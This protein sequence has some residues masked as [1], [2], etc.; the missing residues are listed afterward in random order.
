[1]SGQRDRP[2][3]S[4]A[5]ARAGVEAFKRHRGSIGDL[6]EHNEGS[7]KPM[8][9]AVYEAMSLACRNADASARHSDDDAPLLP[10]Q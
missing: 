5:M 10:R 9:R 3:I 7:L 4:K 6:W 2:V 1:M 8:V